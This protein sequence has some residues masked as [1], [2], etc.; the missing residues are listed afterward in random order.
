M[1]IENH[2]TLPTY[3][4]GTKRTKRGTFSLR[5]TSM[6][7]MF[8]ILLVFLLKSYSA[9]G[10]IM[11]ITKDLKLPESTSQMQP[12]V[13]S[14]IAITQ[15]WVLVDGRPIEKIENIMTNENIL[16]KPLETELRKIRSISERI[17]ALSDDLEGFKGNITIQGNRDITFDL[18]KRI[19]LTCGSTGYNN[20]LL[21][22]SQIE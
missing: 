2:D 12:K 20:M 11:T 4:P 5:L 22:V 17:G 13:T 10:Q 19:M 3:F 6:I 8:T 15:E 14:I 1:K 21:A 7:D 9:E 18:L 16:I